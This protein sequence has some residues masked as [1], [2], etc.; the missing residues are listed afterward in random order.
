MHAFVIGAVGFEYDLARGSGDQL[1]ARVG[2]R[3]AADQEAGKGM[4]DAKWSRSEPT[5]RRVLVDFETAD[6]PLAR[7]PAAHVAAPGDDR[8]AAHGLTN[9]GGAFG[10]PVAEIARLEIEI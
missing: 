4:R 7:M 2:V 8:I 6:P 9:E 5:L 3:A 10:R 1:D